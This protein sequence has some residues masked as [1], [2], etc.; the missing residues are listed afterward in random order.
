M[1]P[2]KVFWYPH[3]SIEVAEAITWNFLLFGLL[4]A[5]TSWVEGTKAGVWALVALDVLSVVAVPYILLSVGIAVISFAR[6]SIEPPSDV[7]E[8]GH[9]PPLPPGGEIE[10]TDAIP[11]HRSKERRL[12]NVPI[13]KE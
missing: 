3:R 12:G 8:E 6:M 13:T 7:P 1:D 11:T 2:R 9:L 10:V 4:L 5:F